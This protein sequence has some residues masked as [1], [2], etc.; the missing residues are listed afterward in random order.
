MKRVPL[1]YLLPFCLLVGA[2]INAN[3]LLRSTE[4]QYHDIIDASSWWQK[5]AIIENCDTTAYQHVID[6]ILINER[7]P[8]VNGF[9]YAFLMATKYKYIPANYDAYY[10]LKNAY[11][12]FDSLDANT[13]YM[14]LFFLRRGAKLGDPRCKSVIKENRSLGIYK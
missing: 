6:S 5:K 12:H 14:A 10:C 4:V 1:R 9:Y 13:R 8:K 11:Q 2:G 7:V 3:S